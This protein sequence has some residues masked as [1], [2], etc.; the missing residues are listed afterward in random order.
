MVDD[1]AKSVNPSPY[2]RHEVLLLNRHS[3]KAT[4]VINVESFDVHEFVLQT[5]YGLLAIRGDELHIKTLDLEGGTVIV[6][7]AVFDLVYF[8]DGLPPAAPKSK[9]FIGKLFRM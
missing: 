5:A 9:G 1:R 3:L 4:G 2:D 8:D 7:G 6:E